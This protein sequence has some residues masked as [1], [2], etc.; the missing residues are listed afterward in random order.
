MTAATNGFCA[1]PSARSDPS[2]GSLGVGPVSP[3]DKLQ[4]CQMARKYPGHSSE[5]GTE[6]ATPEACPTC[7]GVWCDEATQSLLQV[8][9][10]NE[11]QVYPLESDNETTKTWPMTD[12]ASGFCAYPS[13]RSDPTLGG[14][15]LGAAPTSPEEILKVCEMAQKYEGHRAAPGSEC[16]SET[17]CGGCNG[18]WCNGTVQS[19]LQVQAQNETQV[20]PLESDNETAKTWPM[21]DAA[22][23]FCAYPSERSDPTLGGEKLGAAPTSPEEILKVCEMAQKYEG[24]RA[25]PGSECASET[26]CGGCNGVWC[27][28][29]VQSLLQA[30]AQKETQVYPLESD[31]E[32]AKTWPMTDAASGFCAYPSERSDPTLGGEKLG[33]APTS[34]EEILKVCEMA[35]KYEGHR[36]APG[37]ECASETSCGG[38]NGVWCNGTVQSLL[39]V[40]AQNETQVYPLESDNETAKTWPMTDAAS[41][42]CAYPSERSD[43]TLGGEKLGAAPTSPEEILKVCE[44]AQKYEGHRA[45]PGSECA[46]ETSCGG[47]N[48]VWCNGTVQSLLQ[49]QAQNETQVYP[50]ESDNETAKTWPM[51]DAASGFCAYPSERSDPTLGGE[52]LGAAPTSPEEILKVCEMAQK[53]EGHRASPGSECA[54]E[55]SCGGCNGVWCNG[56]VQSLLQVQAQNETQVYP[57]ESDNETAKTWPMTDAASGFCA[58]PSERSDPT[59]GGEK[60]GAAPTSPEEILKVCEMAQKYE[61]HRASPG[62]ECA[63]ETSCGGCNGVW[64]NGTVQSLLQVQAQNETQVYPLES[65]NETAKTWPMTDAASGFCAYPSE[66]SDPTLGGEKLGAAPTSPEEIL[67]V[68]EMAQKYEGHRAAPGSECASETSCGGCNGVWCN[69]TVQA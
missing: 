59:L 28:G 64:C 41:G 21:T 33:A 66:R 63:S 60:L 10:Q 34:P 53:Y 67:K 6:C 11:T 27:N 1:F 13:E 40:Q 37:S 49:V 24:H 12:A 20:Y 61:G 45:A 51:T 42:F 46:S 56:T 19:L 26:S 47:C 54:S 7:N 36:A 3:E 65:D 62:S 14:E 43:P 2:L 23:G 58:Y 4:I 38:C 29:T 9:S 52:K 15:K 25:A 55:T 8:Q 57:L 17:S 32:T 30:Q 69:G 22:S 48:G 35:Q 31:N 68:C 18:V 50:L 5:P 44:M 39:Q 16:A